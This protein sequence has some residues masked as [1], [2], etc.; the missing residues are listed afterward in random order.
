[1]LSYKYADQYLISS[2]LQAA[3]PTLSSDDIDVY[4]EEVESLAKQGGP[5][6]TLTTMMGV[7]TMYNTH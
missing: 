6:Y 3:D 5:Q 7:K 4:V 2:A 1:M